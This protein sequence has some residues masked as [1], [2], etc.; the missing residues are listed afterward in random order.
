MAKAKPE[1]VI[2][3]YR[4]KPGKDK[5][6]RALLAR[7]WPTLRRLRLVTAQ[8]S[9]VFRGL[10]P[11]PRKDK[12]AVGPSTFIEIFAWKDGQAVDTAHH[13]PEVMKVW[14]PMGELCVSMDFPHF[15]RLDR[16]R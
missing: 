6:F 3:T 8:P 5:A 7:H 11:G 16:G 14:E 9:Q 1:T 2:C 15:E 12:H 10:P 4:V 13:S